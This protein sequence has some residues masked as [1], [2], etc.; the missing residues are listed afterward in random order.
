MFLIDK[1]TQFRLIFIPGIGGV[2]ERLKEPVLKTGAGQ[3]AVGSNPTPSVG[4]G[5]KKTGYPDLFGE[6]SLYRF[7]EVRERLNRAPC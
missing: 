1:V 2:T 6:L 4:E 3:P 5:F 7:G